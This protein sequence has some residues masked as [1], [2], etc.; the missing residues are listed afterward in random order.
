MKIGAKIG[1]G[2][3]AEVFEWGEKSKVI[4]I[5]KMK[6]DNSYLEREYNNHVVMWNLGLPVPKVYKMIDLD[7]RSGIVYER[8]F[9]KTLKERFFENIMELDNVE[10]GQFNLED[11]R[12][13]AR[14]FSKVHL[15]SSQQQ[16]KTSQ[17][18]FLK[19]QIDSVHYLDEDEKRLVLQK[20]DGLPQK[21]NVCHGDLNPNNIIIS[22]NEAILI[23]WMN[24]A[25]GNPEVDVAE[26]II[27]IRFAILPANLPQSVIQ[28]FESYR[29]KII[30]TFMDEY[31]KL[32]GTTYDE[33]DPWIVPIAARKL[34]SNGIGEDEKNILLKEIR[35]RLDLGL[36]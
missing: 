25:N 8:I 21:S 33:V 29:E 35:Y 34:S 28:M 7:E 9:G 15:T 14:L 30:E 3:L 11:V 16:L 23:D 22:Q 36:F 5:A 20:L 27:M 17:R 18:D 31:T 24:A 2:A 10:Q 13:I 4:K 26:F 1:E 6:S 12:M 32:T 19:K